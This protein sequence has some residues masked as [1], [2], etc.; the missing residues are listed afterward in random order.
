MS[1]AIDEVNQSSISEAE[2]ASEADA[3]NGDK[4][5]GEVS[6]EASNLHFRHLRPNE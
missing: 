4:A 2:A 5:E 3:S 1:D 6:M